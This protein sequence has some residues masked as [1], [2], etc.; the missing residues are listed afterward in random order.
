MFSES[1]AGRETRRLTYSE[2]QIIVVET[3]SLSELLGEE[4]VGVLRLLLAAVRIVVDVLGLHRR[5]HVARRLPRARGWLSRIL[6]GGDLVFF[7]CRDSIVVVR[8][9]LS[10]LRLF[11]AGWG[12]LAW[13]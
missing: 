12:A 6:F 13:R 11:L 7:S 10:V 2:N 3:F 1:I 4:L 9:S 8:E 5:S